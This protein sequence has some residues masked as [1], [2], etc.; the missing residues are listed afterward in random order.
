[1]PVMMITSI[2]NFSFPVPQRT[3]LL[4]EHEYYI[5]NPYDKTCN[6]RIAN[7]SQNHP[8]IPARWL[9]STGQHGPHP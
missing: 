2:D 7:K 3:G 6:C 9:Q 8:W 4:L 5:Y 1:M